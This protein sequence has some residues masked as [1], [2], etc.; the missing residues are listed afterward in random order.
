MAPPHSPFGTTNAQPRPTSP[1][2]KRRSSGTHAPGRAARRSPT[3]SPPRSC[4]VGLCAPV[5]ARSPHATTTTYPPR[6]TCATPHT[7]TL[8]QTQSPHERRANTHIDTPIHFDSGQD[9]E[10][11][12]HRHPQQREHSRTTTP[13]SPPIAV[14]MSSGTIGSLRPGALPTTP[15]WPTMICKHNAESDHAEPRAPSLANPPFCD[16]STERPNHRLRSWPRRKCTAGKRHAL[17][18]H[19]RHCAKCLWYQALGVPGKPRASCNPP[20]P[21]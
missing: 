20:K 17:R 1:Q 9:G 21:Q 13:R 5:E 4:P 2:T 7:H 11:H 6:N 18:N 14:P 15:T 10:I 3:C 12:H 8:T 19:D 16:T